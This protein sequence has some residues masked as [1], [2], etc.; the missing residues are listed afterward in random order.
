LYGLLFQV[1]D[2][3]KCTLIGVYSKHLCTVLCGM[4]SPLDSDIV[5]TGS[6]D[7]SVHAWRLSKDLH[8]A[9][10][11]FKSKLMHILHLEL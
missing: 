8:N 6:A 3:Q 11:D 9:I 2:V 10:T 5:F 7:H 4:F 1:W